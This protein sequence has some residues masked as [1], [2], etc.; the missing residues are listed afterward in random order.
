M[1]LLSR[2]HGR[3]LPAALAA[4]LFTVVLARTAWVSDDAYITLRTVDNFLHGYGLRWNVAERVQSYTHPLWMFLLTGAYGLTRENYFTIINLCILV[5]CAAMLLAARSARSPLAGA[6]A[7]VLLLGSKAY[8]D[9]STSG[10]ENPL[11]HLLLAAFFLIYWTPGA[12]RVGWLALAA[13]LLMTTRLDAGLVVLPALGVAL[14]GQRRSRAFVLAAL[15]MLPLVTWEVFSVIYYGFPFPNTAYAKLNTGI[16]S[17][18][19]MTQGFIYLLNSLKLD[20][21]TLVVIAVGL[22][23]GCAWTRR[24]GWPVAAGMAIYLVYVVRVGGDFM[25]GRFLTAPFLCA[26]LLLTRMPMPAV[27]AAW[28]LPLALA[29][30]LVLGARAPNAFAGLGPG[31]ERPMA[32]TGITDERAFYYPQ[33]G[34]GRVLTVGWPTHP[35]ALDGLEA[36]KAGARVRVRG[37]AGFFG[38]FAGPPMHLIDFNGLG[39]PLL[40]RLPALIHWRTGHFAR[41]IPEGYLETLQQE[42]ARIADPRVAD[43][44]RRLDTITRGPIWSWRRFSTI[45][46]MNVGAYDSLLED[47]GREIVPAADLR[48]K[49]DGDPWDDPGNIAWVDVLVAGDPSAANAQNTHER[50]IA[51]VFARPQRARRLEISVSGD[52][53]YAI[54][55][56]LGS[57][58]LATEIITPVPG[59]DGSLTVHRFVVPPDASG[60]DRILVEGRLGDYRYSVGHVIV[61]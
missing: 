54:T 41:R 30:A 18:E 5:S 24:A 10:L 17:G 32:A 51:V 60:F 12:G 52:D 45:W 11:T 23:A 4:G 39:D 40:A 16:P 46:E 47:Y 38:F 59:H 14:A 7:V 50:G 31:G 28:P 56:C 61:G 9:F 57:R 33:T 35:W 25:S 37:D 15:G 36:R 3:R 55:Y 49:P 48:V 43:L 6:F 19:L 42:K 29:M 53:R 34:L 1:D 27:A 44:H 20:P 58:R 8:V 26:V 22:V 2:V 21:L 13:S